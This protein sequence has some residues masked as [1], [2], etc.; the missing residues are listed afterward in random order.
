MVS[1]GLKYSTNA[2]NNNLLNSA[3]VSPSI[4]RKSELEKGILASIAIH[5]LLENVSSD[6]LKIK[7][8][9]EEDAVEAKNSLGSYFVEGLII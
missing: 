4:N 7:I 5:A 8:K 3:L 2:Q 9:Q 1:M 6:F